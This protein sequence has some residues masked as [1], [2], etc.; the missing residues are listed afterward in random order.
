MKNRR[1]KQEKELFPLRLKTSFAMNHSAFNSTPNNFR[2]L[3][4]V[5]GAGVA[6]SV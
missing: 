4:S 2:G 1:S 5:V 6:Q 3:Y